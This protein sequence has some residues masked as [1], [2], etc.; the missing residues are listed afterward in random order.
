MEAYLPF[1]IWGG[2]FV[3]TV[4]AEIAS[5]QLVSIW[6]AAG[7]LAAFLAACFG[8]SVLVQLVLFAAISVLLLLL[9]RPILKKIFSFRIKNTN[10]QEIGRIAVVIQ[11]IDS[12]KGTGRVR[13][14]GVDWIAVSQT[15]EP[16]PAQ[17]SV[18]IESIDGS[19]LFVTALPE[20][21]VMTSAHTA[22]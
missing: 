16:I 2:L 6:F 3:L 11:P 7:S 9:T 21:A 4:V 18:R 14:D 13:L 19:K 8:A 15:G 1:L 5:Q 22:S 17:R 12:V 10:S 20:A